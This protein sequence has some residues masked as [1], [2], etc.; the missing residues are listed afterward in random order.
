MLSCRY[1]VVHEEISRDVRAGHGCV[2][3]RTLRCCDV[4]KDALN[5]ANQIRLSDWE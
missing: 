4:K 1:V 2:E 3:K 5:H